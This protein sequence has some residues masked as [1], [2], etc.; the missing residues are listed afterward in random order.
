MLQR[1][2]VAS[3]GVVKAT[4]SSTNASDSPSIG[5]TIFPMLSDTVF[6]LCLICILILDLHLSFNVAVTSN[7]FSSA[8]EC[9]NP[10]PSVLGELSPKSH[11]TLSLIPVAARKIIWSSA[12]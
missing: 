12:V 6:S 4:G 7:I 10:T 2:E 5:S 8:K 11:V 1:Y 9:L 3:I